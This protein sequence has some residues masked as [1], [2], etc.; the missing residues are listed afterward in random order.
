MARRPYTP[1]ASSSP[2]A[3][4]DLGSSSAATLFL[5]SGE[6]IVGELLSGDGKSIIVGLPASK[7]GRIPLGQP[8]GFELKSYGKAQRIFVVATSHD[9]Q[10]SVHT[11]R[12]VLSNR[13]TIEGAPGSL[14][15]ALF[16]ERAAFRLPVNRDNVQGTSICSVTPSARGI[17]PGGAR[18]SVRDSRFKATLLDMSFDGLGVLVSKETDA[19]LKGA[20]CVHVE[21]TTHLGIITIEG[22]ICHRKEMPRGGGVT[23]GIAA[24]ASRTARWKETDEQLLRRFI[25]E[26]QRSS[27]E[28]LRRA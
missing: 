18:T 11:V 14:Q 9:E 10:D 27:L 5:V 6:V 21:I 25:T 8:F 26:Q 12:L 22:L 4:T 16:N 19:G 7:H 20:D 24:G 28:R 15:T 13:A 17:R 1:F 3:T 23:Y 2:S